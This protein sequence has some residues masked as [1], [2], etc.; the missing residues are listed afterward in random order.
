MAVGMGKSLFAGSIEK[1]AT[2]KSATVVSPPLERL[3]AWNFRKKWEPK[4]NGRKIQPR[5]KR[6]IYR[7]VVSL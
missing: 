5:Q 1:I 3:T 2:E 6:I 4:V 7:H